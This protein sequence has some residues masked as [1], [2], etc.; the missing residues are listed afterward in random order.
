M[1]TR[2]RGHV[3]QRGETF[4]AYWRAR[5]EN[6]Q[7]RQRSKGGF[8]NAETADRY[9]TRVLRDL[10]I[11]NYVEPDR[12]A[13]SQTFA[14][15]VRSDWLPAIR[16]TVR[17]STFASYR[18]NLELHVIPRLGTLRLAEITPERLNV[19]YGQ[20]LAS[21]S[22]KGKKPR[23]L[24]PRTVRYVHTIIR[25]LL[26]DAVLWDRIARNPAERA[27]PPVSARGERPV[28]STVELR[29]FL[30]H[31][32]NERLYAAWLL[33]ATTGLRR[34]EA[35]G[36]R[37]SDLDLDA[38][39]LTV[40]QS[41]VAIGYEVRVSAPKTERGRRRIGIDPATVAALR[42]WRA[43]QAEE[44]LAW[45]PAWTDSG[46]VF[47]REDGAP[48]HPQSLSQT[49]ERHVR[50]AKLPTIRLHDV[51]H[52]YAT[53]ALTSGVAPKVLSERLGH[54]SI[55]ITADV[56]QHVLPELDDQAA[57]QVAAVILG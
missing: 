33:L 29:Q 31:V 35:L 24:S 42:T 6:G 1:S 38:G 52:S 50:D 56:Y 30:E 11:G 57:A 49:F 45:G 19:M 22:R 53:A 25:R 34:G 10:D 20:L 4:T 36:L 17:P 37:W 16:A 14:Q 40:Q 51:R 5:G 39:K 23:G 8:A 46:F 26:K 54:S 27:T 47:T 28:W 9:L 48:L 13:R 15:F 2:R 55:A 21:G 41:L 44:R 18:D 12:K 7:S 43:R 32:A 3:R